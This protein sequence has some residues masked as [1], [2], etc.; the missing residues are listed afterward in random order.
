M[1]W[2][3]PCIDADLRHKVP[4]RIVAHFIDDRTFYGF[5]IIPQNANLSSNGRRRDFMVAG[6]HNGTNASLD[7]LR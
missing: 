6:N 2:G 7:T 3:Y 5:C 4:Q 1:L